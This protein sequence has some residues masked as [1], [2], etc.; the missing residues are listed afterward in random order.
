MVKQ[1]KIVVFDLD[2]TLGNFVELGMFCD[3]LE[4]VTNK[5]IANEEFYKILNLFYE[6]LRHKIK[7]I[8]KYLLHKKKRNDCSKIMLYT[9]NQGPR[10][11]AEKIC[12]YFNH[13]FKT[14]I[15]D[16]IIAAFKVKGVRVEL[17]RTS[18]DKS[19]ED[20]IHCTKVPPNTEIC[21]LDDQY[22]PLME[23]DAVYYINIKPYTYSIAFQD[24][25]ERY[26]DNFNLTTNKKEFISKIIN[27]MREFNYTHI[28]KTEE[29]LK[30]DN[31]ISKKIMMHLEEF[32]NK[33]K[34]QTRKKKNKNKR[35]TQKMF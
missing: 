24:M 8:L 12:S 35:K 25:A 1:C 33:N 3:A 34:V 29:E 31:I 21:F 7:E 15:F 5:K 6:F 10:E 18:H 4:N 19:V 28:K 30:I 22:H 14:E 32:F 11:W 9:N 16:Q 13:E 17:C 23:N 27:Y 20:L 2:E 26:Y